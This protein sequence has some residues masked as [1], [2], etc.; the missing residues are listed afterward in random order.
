MTGKPTYDKSKPRRIKDE[1]QKEKISLMITLLV[2]CC[3]LLY[4]FHYVLGISTGFT[5]FF[6]IP[7]I[8]ASLWWQRKGLG[9]ALFL[10]LSLLF[11]H[12]SFSYSIGSGNDYFRAL[13]FVV[14]G[15]AAVLVRER[16]MKGEKSLRVSEESFKNLFENMNSG[17]AIY[18]AENNGE[19]FI[20][21]DLNK[22]GE[23]IDKVTRGE[24]IGK[25]VLEI[26]PSVKDFGLFD[27]FQR[28]WKTG[29]PGKGQPL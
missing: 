4:Y 7:I 1:R 8:L 13:M 24:I 12:Y 26:F 9:V 15:F 5:H 10:A 14:V 21:K 17:V 22:T 27:M 2:G 11:S 20:F 28:V 23:R 18:E 29:Q 6:Y 16:M 25:S 3:F 19:D